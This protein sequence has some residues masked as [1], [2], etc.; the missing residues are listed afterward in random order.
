MRWPL[1]LLVLSTLLACKREAPKE[2]A[3]PAKSA[4]PVAAAAP[5][6]KKKVKVAAPPISAESDKA[7]TFAGKDTKVVVCKL[8]ESAPPMIDKDWWHHS[9]TGMAVARD[10]TLY[11][12]DHEQKLRHYVN[13]SE[14]GCE[15]ALDESFGKGGVMDFQSSRGSVI[16]DVATDDKGA[17]Y[18]SWHK[19]PK[20]IVGN[21]VTEHC[22]D[23]IRADAWSPLVVAD[24]N[25][26]RGEGCT[27]KYAKGLLNGFDPS[28]PQYDQPKVVGLFGEELVSHGVDIEKGKSVHKVGVH[29]L[30]GKR[31]LVLGGHADD[32]MYSIKHATSCG[33]DLCVLDSP[34][35]STSLLRW[36][37]DGKFLGKVTLTD[38]SMNGSEIGWSKAGLYVGG[39]IRGEK[40][41][42]V[43]VIVL[44]PGA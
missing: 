8:D 35:S 22:S 44:L 5:K 31:R 6:A 32:A 12:V 10:G 18:F 39:A 2:D 27:G 36:T 33:G 3:A 38:L 1:A 9:L 13:Q 28:V 21:E 20:K 42:W 40:S 15:L 19:A 7:I 4:A 23:F 17:V 43:G 41:E 37:K 29:G 26:T 25:V 16:N 11:V 24:G 30:D 34:L 14:G